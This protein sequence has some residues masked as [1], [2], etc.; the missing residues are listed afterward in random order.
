MCTINPQ[1]QDDEIRDVV[2]ALDQKARSVYQ[3]KG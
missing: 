2:K 1:T 3:G